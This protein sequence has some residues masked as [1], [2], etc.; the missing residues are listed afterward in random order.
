MIAVWLGLLL[1]STPVA[2]AAVNTDLE[3][4][5]DPDAQRLE[6]V[7]ALE[8]TDKI[9]PAKLRLASQAEIL[10]VESSGQPLPYT[11]QG[12]VLA[13]DWPGE[14][15]TR[16]VT[17]RYRASFSDPLPRETV[18]V[19]DPSFGVRAVISPAGTYLAA[20][21]AWFPQADGVRSRHRITVKAPPGM[22]A[23][24]AGSFLGRRDTP[25]ATIS[26]WHNDFPLAGLA[27]AA[28]RFEI[29]S[30]ELD[31]IQL[32]TF[33]SQGNADLAPAY[34]SAMRRHLAFYRER[35]GPYP[36]SKFAVVENFLPT[37][38]GLPSW[39]LLGQSVVRLPFLLDTS[40]PHEIVHSWWGNA[41]E[42]NY[43]KG[44]WAEGLATYLADYLLKEVSEPHEALEYRRK[45][46][47]DY[48]A[49]VTTPSN[50]FPLTAFAGRMSKS[51]QAIGY[52]KGAMV[53]HQLRR[54]VGDEIFWQA[55]RTMVTTGN[56]RT[57]GWREIEAIF[58]KA[59]GRDLR[60]F[61][62]QWLERRG[63][64]QLAFDAVRAT[65]SA[66]GWAVS[67]I[68]RQHGD[69]YRLD[70]PLQLSLASGE[71]VEH[72]VRL[73]GSR[74]PFVL[75]AASRPLK[76]AA[77]PQSHLFRRLQVE[78]L[79][80]TVNDLL[81]AARPLV[82][83]ADGQQHLVAAL[84]DLI[85][86]LQWPNPEFVG[87][88]AVT[89]NELQR[90][91]LLLLGWP[92]RRELQPPLPPGL[93][94]ISGNETA[95]RIDAAERSGDLLF[96]VLNQRSDG[97]GARALILAHDAESLGRAAAKISHYGR[98]SLLLFEGGR[99]LLKTTR[100]PSAS[101]LRITLDKESSP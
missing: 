75:T 25:G 6:G 100:E 57:L 65:P 76:L 23:V 77:D 37:G 78:E 99:N 97:S 92:R 96:T 41:V 88:A 55:L 33:L 87:E 101:P 13:I 16:R 5:L 29:A 18:G 86:G 58:S 67:G 61:F 72:S 11:F 69:P 28:G 50:D 31:G 68:V 47:R 42:V 34:L 3:L 90:R 54:E 7:A 70:L 98:Y 84:N 24:T 15:G 8:F 49:L 9:I 94:I 10:G 63:A 89:A 79:P 22:I 40:L 17:V 21:V 95:W 82:I 56:G 81:Y 80:A 46:L 59:A 38:Y 73:N 52:G 14:S 19:E 66:Q 35:L 64:P 1:T 62:A 12:G 4:Q 51:E 39:T 44:N 60:W 32:L 30:D 43:A 27:L 83:V 74:T 36:F 91:D 53:F 85:K 71:Q 20:G 45:L 93:A 2:T 26:E 48:A